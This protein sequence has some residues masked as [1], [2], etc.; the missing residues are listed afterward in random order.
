MI[1]AGGFKNRD[2]VKLRW[3]PE[4]DCFQRVLHFDY[5]LPHSIKNF[6]NHIAALRG[7]GGSRLALQEVHKIDFLVWIFFVIGPLPV[8]VAVACLLSHPNILAV[9][10]GRF[11]LSHWIFNNPDRW[12]E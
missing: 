8:L 2:G 11:A 3:H 4:L 7:G 1:K 5:P 9:A 10:P 6:V 12:R